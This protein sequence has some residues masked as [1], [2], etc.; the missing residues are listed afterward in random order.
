MEASTQRGRTHGYARILALAL[1]VAVFLVAAMPG[2]AASAKESDLSK[3]EQEILDTDRK[4]TDTEDSVDFE[5]VETMSQGDFDASVN[6]P[7][8]D[9][10]LRALPERCRTAVE[11]DSE[12]LVVP[13][14]A[15]GVAYWHPDHPGAIIDLGGTTGLLS[16]LTSPG[17]III[18]TNNNDFINASNATDVICA[19]AGRDTVFGNHG[20]D[21]IFGQ[22]GA[23]VLNG[24]PDRDTIF[25]G[26]GGDVINGDRGRDTLCGEAGNDALFGGPDRDTISG[27][28]GVDTIDYGAEGLFP[29]FQGEPVEPDPCP[30]SSS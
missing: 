2:G 4:D 24:G 12:F 29:G 7:L 19:G 13:E 27:G 6:H 5:A 14:P 20:H 17:S 16:G 8:F 1:A 3:A 10:F 11:T 26:T 23:D 22:V 28:T 9:E 25:G 15:N 21:V 18:G 30:V